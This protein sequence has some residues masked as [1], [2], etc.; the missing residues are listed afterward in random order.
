MTWMPPVKQ[1]KWPCQ[2]SDSSLTWVCD[3]NSLPCLLVVIEVDGVGRP[4]VAH[5]HA[6]E[7]GEQ[8]LDDGQ[9]DGEAVLRPLLTHVC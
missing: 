9:R 6:V 1:L 3:G 5:E 8:E 2:V 4:S 7:D